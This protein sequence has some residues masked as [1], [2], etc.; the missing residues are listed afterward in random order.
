MKKLFIVGC[1]RS[2]T[3]LLQQAL[4]RHSAVVIPPE[5][6]LFNYFFGRSRRCQR[7]HL[8]RLNEDLGIDLS[9][10]ARKI[11]TVDEARKFYE[12]MAAAYVDRLG[13]T[14][15]AYLGDKTPE[16]TGHLAHIDRLFPDAKYIFMV[17]DGR[18]VALSLTRVPW[19]NCD[20][21][22]GFLIWLHFWRIFKQTQATGSFDIHYLRYE[23]LVS[24]PED[25]LIQVL[26]FLGLPHEPAVWTGSG[27]KEG[28]PKREYEWKAGALEKIT[29]CYAGRWKRELSETELGRLNYLGRKALP[30]LGYDV[31]NSLESQLSLAFRLTLPCRVVRSALSLPLPFLIHELFHAPSGRRGCQQMQRT[32]ETREKCPG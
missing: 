23:D 19:I 5:T 1:P 9:V 14:E 4:N 28:I 22:T 26:T 6:K 24:D 18:D 7:I 25:E 17:R 13:R 30:D 16:Q 10:P 8:K 29:D 15:V 2:G 12:Q 32:S 3:T 27:N 31:D 11:R 20:V 21:Y